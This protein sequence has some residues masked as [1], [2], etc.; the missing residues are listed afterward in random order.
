MHHDRASSCFL[1]RMSPHDCSIACSLYSAT[2]TATPPLSAELGCVFHQIDSL[3]KFARSYPDESMIAKVG[4]FVPGSLLAS[5]ASMPEAANLALLDGN[6]AAVERARRP[7]AFLRFLLHHLHKEI[8]S[9]RKASGCKVIDTLH[10]FS[11]VS[12]NEFI[13]GSGLPVVSKQHAMT[14]DLSYDPFVKKPD[15]VKFGEVLRHALSKEA[16][17][18]AWCKESRSYETVVQ[19]KIAT[20]L[21]SILTL[22]CCCAG[23]HNEEGLSMWRNNSPENGHWLPEHVEVEI[24]K[25]GNVV[26]RELVDGDGTGEKVW[27]EFKGDSALPP[28]V[29]DIVMSNLGASRKHRYRLE[30]VLS[31]VRDDMDSGSKEEVLGHH[32][33]HA[34]VPPN[35]KRQGYVMQRIKAQMVA[36]ANFDAAQANAPDKLTLTSNI[37]Q[38]VFE[39]RIKDAKDRIEAMEETNAEDDWVLFN[40][41]VVSNTVAEDARAFHVPFKDPCLIMFRAVDDNGN[42]NKKERKNSDSG[43]DSTKLGLSCMQTKSIYTGRKSEYYPHRSNSECWYA[44]TMSC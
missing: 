28:A 19:R 44:N 26:V 17:L 5:F 40:G 9:N 30:A 33:L 29:A 27:M 20:S 25:N 23:K 16:P 41:F 10:G 37:K 7:E 12:I 14:L 38:E 11:F 21:P 35:Y 3:S 15:G 34:R 42:K 4:A 8:V 2:A 31:F 22:S 24:E 1:R 6:P 13:T 36:S 18:R 43:K 32:V 39:N